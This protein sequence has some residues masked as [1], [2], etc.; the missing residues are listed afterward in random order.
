MQ[1]IFGVAILGNLTPPKL[2]WEPSAAVF[3]RLS[4]VPLHY[5]YA[6]SVQIAS[7]KCERLGGPERSNLQIAPMT[8]D[9]DVH[10]LIDK[11]MQ[12]ASTFV[13]NH[14]SNTNI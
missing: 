11:L 8:H 4:S 9:S 12:A 6:S 5:G 2:Q 13:C 7:T 14:S 3:L 1:G 10:H